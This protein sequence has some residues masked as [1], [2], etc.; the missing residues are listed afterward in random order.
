MNAEAIH[1]FNVVVTLSNK[2]WDLVLGG[3]AGPFN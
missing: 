1:I 3:C 2:V